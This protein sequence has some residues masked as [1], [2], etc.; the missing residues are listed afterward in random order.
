MIVAI[1]LY[2]S[3]LADKKNNIIKDL[4]KEYYRKCENEPD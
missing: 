1:N 2:F 4:S 3:K